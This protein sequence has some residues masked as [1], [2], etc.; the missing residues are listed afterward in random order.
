MNTSQE[1]KPNQNSTSTTIKGS[2]VPVK[3]REAGIGSTIV[4]ESLLNLCGQLLPGFKDQN[5]VWARSIFPQQSRLFN[6]SFGVDR[7]EADFRGDRAVRDRYDLLSAVHFGDA[8]ASA[9]VY[10]PTLAHL[11]SFHENVTFSTLDSFLKT[12][13]LQLAPVEVLL[14]TLLT[15]LV[16]RSYDSVA[17][18]GSRVTTSEHHL[19]IPGPAYTSERTVISA[20]GHLRDG[21]GTT[22]DALFGARTGP[23]GLEFFLPYIVSTTTGGWI[24]GTLF[25]VQSLQDSHA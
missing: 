22:R 25:L 19:R 3:V 14:S 13:R 18:D 12:N 11:V 1:S 2:I 4:F 24:P 23:R 20:G 21:D 9:K 7:S 6:A 8:D 10:V 17:F 15:N 16:T 5:A